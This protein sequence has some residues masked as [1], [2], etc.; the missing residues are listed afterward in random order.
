MATK[1]ISEFFCLQYYFFE[2]TFTT[3]KPKTVE[4]KGF[5]PL[6]LMMEDPDPYLWL[7]DPEGPK[8]YGSGTLLKTIFSPGGEVVGFSFC[9]FPRHSSALLFIL[10][11]LY[12]HH[13]F[14]HSR[15]PL[16]AL[17]PLRLD[18]YSSEAKFLVPDLGGGG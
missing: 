10:I 6:F 17:S 12:F 15:T 14:S 1:N 3:K 4:I 7:T 9:D 5:L 2:G 13:I 18:R 16:A 11:A 8:T